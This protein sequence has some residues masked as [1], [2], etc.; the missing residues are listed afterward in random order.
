[1]LRV[2]VGLLLRKP[3]QEMPRMSIPLHTVMQLTPSTAAGPGSSPYDM[4]LFKAVLP[5]QQ[6]APAP[7]AAAGTTKD[8]AASAATA[9]ADPSAG[10]DGFSRSSSCSCCSLALTGEEGAAAAS[11]EIA[12]AAAG[13]GHAAWPIEPMHSWESCS[14]EMQDVHHEAA[15]AVLAGQ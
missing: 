1:V 5:E 15:H 9:A 8:V 6:Q 7:T 11:A 14:T 10:I 3:L 13:D 4:T 12:A 2:L